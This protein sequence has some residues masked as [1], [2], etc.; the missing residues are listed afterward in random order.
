MY[1]RCV[2]QTYS[3][4]NVYRPVAPLLA[5]R[6]VPVLAEPPLTLERQ[7]TTFAGIDTQVIIDDKIDGKVQAISF[8]R[9]S[10]G[11][12]AGHYITVEIHRLLLDDGVGELP[13]HLDS[14]YV[15]ATSE[16]GDRVLVWGARDLTLESISSGVAVDDIV[17]EEK[18]V[19]SAKEFVPGK[20]LPRENQIAEVIRVLEEMLEVSDEEE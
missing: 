18:L 14:L 11:P 2:Q 5:K 9:E 15:I 6:V 13:E 19:Y 3:P 8:E 1:N 20:R 12:G 16:F 7:F 17:V 10:I 4:I